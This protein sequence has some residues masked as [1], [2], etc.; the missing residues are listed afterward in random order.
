LNVCSRIHVELTCFGDVEGI[1]QE[2][3]ARRAQARVSKPSS[4][5]EIS[6]IP[7]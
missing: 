7:G 2:L 4:A 6:N 5:V 1:G 3:R